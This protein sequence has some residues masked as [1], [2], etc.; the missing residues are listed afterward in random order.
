MRFYYNWS[1]LAVMVLV[2]GGILAFCNWFILKTIRQAWMLR[3][4]FRVSFSI[5]MSNRNIPFYFNRHRMSRS[6]CKEHKTAHM[7]VLV[8]VAFLLCNFLAS[9]LNGIETVHLELCLRNVKTGEH[10]SECNR[11]PDY[12]YFIMDLNNFLILLGSSVNFFIYVIHSRRFRRYELCILNLNMKFMYHKI[13]DNIFS[14]QVF[15]C[16]IKI[17]FVQ[18]YFLS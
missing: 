1:Y 18:D 13:I 16:S 2:P 11:Q 4:I 12:L 10:R 7:L 17:D 3:L 8:V 5:L 15:Q 14:R 9:V 6:R